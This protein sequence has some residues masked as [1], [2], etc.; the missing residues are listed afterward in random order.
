MAFTYPPAS[1][2]ILAGVSNFYRIRGETI[3]VVGSAFADV[4]PGD[5]IPINVGFSA[6]V[7]GPES[8]YE[9]YEL[10]YPDPLAPGGL[11]SIVF[12]RDAPFIGNITADNSTTYGGTNQLK[13]A[14]IRI[15]D[16]GP[17]IGTF[18]NGAFTLAD[19]SV[20]LIV[21]T[22]KP[23]NQLATQRVVKRREGNVALV[24]GINRYYIP[25]YGRNYFR[26]SCDRQLVGAAPILSV[27][28]E[29][30]TIHLPM[31]SSDIINPNLS[32]KS[33]TQ[34]EQTE[35][36]PDT[37]LGPV[38]GIPITH[39]HDATKDGFFDFYEVTIT[40]DVVL[41]PSDFNDGRGV[42]LDMEVRD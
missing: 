9:K 15:G 12:S 35:I 41:L 17:M 23:P 25:G 36:L 16:N 3:D 34:L 10:F 30:I 21:Y 2:D 19:A 28:A 38:A 33:S 20:D 7:V 5:L 14:F 6:I 32:G 27:K 22:G 13:Q 40:S 39:V 4:A 29:G 1:A 8:D 37:P 31:Y 18:I 24:A 11:Q 42:H 26:V